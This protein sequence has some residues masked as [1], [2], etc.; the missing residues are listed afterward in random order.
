MLPIPEGSEAYSEESQSTDYG[1]VQEALDQP[2][3]LIH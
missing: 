3:G 1:D 2:T